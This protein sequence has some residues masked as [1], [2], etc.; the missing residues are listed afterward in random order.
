M[1]YN[2]E[3]YSRIIYK[4]NTLE[5]VF[6][7]LGEV[8]LRERYMLKI[9]IVLITLVSSHSF[10]QEQNEKTKTSAETSDATVVSVSAQDRAVNGNE[11]LDTSKPSTESDRDSA[12]DSGEL[13]GKNSDT[14]DV[15]VVYRINGDLDPNLKIETESD[16]ST[17]FCDPDFDRECEE[18]I[19]IPKSE[20][21]RQF[22]VISH[23]VINR[24]NGEA[25]EEDRVRNSDRSTEVVYRNDGGLGRSTEVVYRENGDPAYDRSHRI[26]MR[27]RGTDKV[28]IATMR[29]VSLNRESDREVERE[30]EVS[31]EAQEEAKEESRGSRRTMWLSR[32]ERA[33][34]SED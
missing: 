29:E 12:V 18:D 26:R 30:E 11:E 13:D 10:A 1:G 33:Q 25:P 21:L 4:Q 17:A 5:K 15:Q 2:I 23:E 8:N 16:M 7:W 28:Y 31:K 6:N 20:K 14:A 9:L 3:R 34:G 22:D 19:S 24:E 32:L 27:E